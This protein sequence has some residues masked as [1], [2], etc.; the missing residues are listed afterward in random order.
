MSNSHRATPWLGR[1]PRFLLLL[2]LVACTSQP[3]QAAEV[4]Y[5]AAVRPWEHERS[6]IPVDPRIRFG[7]LDNGMR[8]AWVKNA[9]PK[10]RS[11]LR[12]HVD[13][14]SLAEDDSER[15]M[16]HFLEHMAFNG[17]KDWPGTS[18]I[19]WFQQQGMAFGPDTNA[20]TGFSE[21]VYEIDLPTSDPRSIGEGLSVF[22]GFV[23]GMLLDP[24]EVEDEKGVIDAEERERDSPNM[25]MLERSLEIEL[26]GTRIPSRLPIGEKAVREEFTAESVRRFYRRWYRPEK[27]TLVLVGDFGDLDPTAMIA[28][29][30]AD[31]QVPREKPLSEPA[32][33]KPTFPRPFYS[34][35]EDDAS[36]VNISISRARPWEDRPDDLAHARRDLPLSFARQMLNLRLHELS[37]E[38]DAPFIGAGAGSLRDNGLRAEEGESL[39]IQCTGE[40]WA[41]ALAACNVELRRALEKGFE[42]EEFAEVRADTLRSL[43]EAV[44]RE[45]T[46][47]SRN[48]ATELVTASEDRHVPASA[49]AEREIY[50]PMIEALD[51]K[52]CHEAYTEAWKRG[53]WVVSVS[54][55]V[56]LGPDGEKA[57]REAWE[58]S[59]AIPVEAKE[60]QADAPFAYSSDPTKSG[61][62]ASRSHQEEFDLHQ[63]VFENGVK[64]HVKKTDFQEKQILAYALVGEGELSL[65]PKDRVLGIAASSVFTGGGLGAH[66]DDQIRRLTAGRRVGVGFDMGEQAFSVGGPTTRE[67]LLLQCELMRAYLV[68]PGWREEGL[69]QLQQQIPVWFE[70]FEHQPSGPLT[71]EFLPEFYSNDARARFPSRER[72]ESL[73]TEQ[74]RD[75]LR[76][77]LDAAPI[78]LVFI[79]DLDVDAVVDAAAKT[80]GTLPERRA[81]DPHEERLKPVELQA[82]LRRDYA[83]E[84]DDP[85]TFVMLAYPATDGRDAATRRRLHFLG[86][87]LSD[88]LRVQ[89]REKLGAAYSPSAGAQASEST[90]RDGWIAIQATAEPDKV[91]EV[92]EACLAAADEMATKGLTDEEIE[93]QRKP[94]QAEIRERLRTN[95]YW[96][97]ALSGLHDGKDAFADMRTYATFVD[98]IG[99]EELERLARE[100]LPK[101]RASVAVV[102]PKKSP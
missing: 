8:Y 37:K 90:P 61:A 72:F 86:S 101:S 81:R 50:R 97:R 40:K 76:A 79:G 24:Q 65:D 88:R 51:A 55:N 25:R 52:A 19:E 41:Q 82:G 12:L 57:L 1:A 48:W 5:A 10:N 100:Y 15:G 21:T 56:D 69:R 53:E 16:A 87:V 95:G 43:D 63:V 84:T 66:D 27:L 32:I 45:R 75:W 38:E 74:V 73:T 71:L 36:A 64:L 13:V 89:I 78:D 77:S 22:R 11:C 102:A 29:T 62:I 42:D 68:D 17:T 14:G 9:E 83:I 23:D 96:L 3:Q 4:R 26:A 18:L 49:A 99:R 67:D 54:G 60:S 20:M 7:R 28:Q 2:A 92:V 70:S 98:S 34:I 94:V 6:D 44:D 47:S 30:F 85:K 59:L 35:E 39:D 31:L 33:G 58:A 91:A 46:R 93:R 80:F